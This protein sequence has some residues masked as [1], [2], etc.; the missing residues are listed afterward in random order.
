MADDDD[1]PMP[2]PQYEGSPLRCY[3]L[4]LEFTIP[5]AILRNQHGLVA[6]DY[7]RW[8]AIWERLRV[9]QRR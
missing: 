7:H 1:R 4:P 6:R 3:Q 5:R 2:L 9:M 8:H